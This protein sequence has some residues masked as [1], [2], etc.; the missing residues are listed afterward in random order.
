MVKKELLQMRLLK[1]TPKMLQ[2]AAADTPKAEVIRCTDTYSYERV[3]RQYRL[4][5]RC[6]V[7]NSI[8]KVALFSPEAMRLGG[9]MPVY[10]LYIDKSASRFL[11]YDPVGK[12][13][14]TAKLDRLDWPVPSYEAWESWMSPAD[15]KTV[16]SYLGTKEGSITDILSYQRDVRDQELLARHRKQTDP[17]DVDLA[18]VPP[19]PKDW[20]HWVSKVGIPQNYIFYQYDKKGVHSGYCTYCDKEVPIKH[21]HYNKPGRCPCCRHKVTYKS[22]GKF[23]RLWTGRSYVYLLQRCKDGFVIREFT[24]ERFYRK[25][26]YQTPSLSIHEIRRVICDKAALP[27]RAYYWGDYKHKAFRWIS[28]CIC[29]PSYYAHY[30][31]G[32]SEIGRVYGRTIPSL[33]KHELARTGLPELIRRV[34]ADPEHYLVVLREVPLLEKISKAKLPRLA[35]ECTNNYYTFKER[36]GGSAATSLTGILGINQ[37]KLK[38]LRAQNGG[39][40][41]LD[42]LLLNRLPTQISRMMSLRGFVPR[43]SRRTTCGLSRAK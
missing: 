39:L 5:A 28:S 35:R 29:S 1:A 27:L 20:E 41:F 32:G 36:F 2:L 3:R 24:A 15:M 37:E 23:G 22:I 9:R 12:R 26:S 42:W 25:E 34:P 4:F 43:R 31:Y 21:P 18:Q 7:E 14:L 40:R 13:W 38:R 17:W 8:L 19:L 30:G 33:A 10:E 6:A 11:T 16:Q